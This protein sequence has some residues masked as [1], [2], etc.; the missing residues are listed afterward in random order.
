MS[1]SLEIEAKVMLNEE[2]YKKLVSSFPGSK[3]YK[4][5]NFYIGNNEVLPLRIRLKDGKYELT[6]KKHS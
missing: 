4:Q 3:S 2:E 5:E 1:K 6:Y